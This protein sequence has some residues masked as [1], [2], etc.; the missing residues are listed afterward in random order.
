MTDCLFCRIA[1]HEI[2]VEAV[3][4]D[5]HLIAF[6]DI[7][8]QAPAHLLYIPKQHFADLTE[9]PKEILGHL[10]SE[11]AALA[12]RELPDG[13][14]IV[15]NTGVDAGQTVQHLHLHILG[16]RFMGWPPG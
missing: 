16:G 14:R 3:C 12:K 7:Y 13:F 8:P 1:R 9:A 15:L 10:L 4:E 5:E 11:A 6:R 2:P